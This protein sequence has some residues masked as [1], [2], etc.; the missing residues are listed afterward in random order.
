MAKKRGLDGGSERVAKVA[1]AGILMPG[2]DMRRLIKEM[3]AELDQLA[4]EGVVEDATE[5]LLRYIAETV[6]AIGT[7][8]HRV[9]YWAT[10][11][12]TVLIGGP[13]IR[14]DGEVPHMV[15]FETQMVTRDSVFPSWKRDGEY[16]IPVVTLG[17]YIDEELYRSAEWRGRLTAFDRAAYECNQAKLERHLHMNMQVEDFLPLFYQ[18][19]D[20]FKALNVLTS[21]VAVSV[22]LKGLDFWLDRHLGGSY[23]EYRR[24]HGF[25][26]EIPQEVIRS[27]K[28]QYVVPPTRSDVRTFLRGQDHPEREISGGEVIRASE[29]S[30]K[31]AR[32]FGDALRLYHK[33]K[34]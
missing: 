18:A 33:A 12:A 3:Q 5:A 7:A 23:A 9:A 4:P 29:M 34:L 22:E 28:D 21:S 15:E 14:W 8:V 1:G 10:Y 17:R 19:V 11:G 16:V 27:A 25:G 31:E 13:R 6:L 30:Q 32:L 26:T 24:E 2:V 20:A